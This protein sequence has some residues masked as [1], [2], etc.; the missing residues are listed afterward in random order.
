MHIRLNRFY[1]LL[2]VLCTAGYVYLYISF[3]A[4]NT[5][6]SPLEF[7]LVKKVAHVPCPS[8]GSTRAILTLAQGEFKAALLLNPLGYLSA[9]GL[10]VLPL[11]ILADAIRRKTSLFIFYQKAEDF[12]K[13]PMHAVPLILLF[14]LN[15]IWNISK[16]L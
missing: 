12:L 10:I 6:S 11:W 9:I 8:C 3:V 15:W 7:C 14:I 13:K 2:F 1:L 4:H 5:N 16:T